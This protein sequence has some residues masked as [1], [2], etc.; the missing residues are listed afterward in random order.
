M[1]ETKTKTRFS[2]KRRNLKSERA[3]KT[4]NSTQKEKLAS[5]NSDAG[6]PTVS[7]IS[8]EEA[9][10][11]DLELFNEYQFSVD[12]LMELAGYSC[13]VAIAKAYPLNTLPKIGGTVLICVGPGNNGGDGL[14][15]ARHLKMF[16]Y[17]P[18]IFYPKRPDKTLYKNLAHQCAA[19]DVPF[20][21]YLP[22]SKLLDE[23]YNF[24][25]DAIFGF[26]FKGDVRPPFADVLKT[27]KEI[28]IPLCS[29]DIPSGWDVEKGNPEGISPEM[30]ISLTAPKK[31]A[32]LFKGKHHYLG[33]RF[34]P[35]DLAKKYELNLPDYPGTECC[36]ELK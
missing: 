33:G 16:G 30:L 13:A 36:M 34:V 10:K 31:C 27:L 17:E 14:V 19:L 24:V 35:P 32:Q 8:Q 4:E 25:V 1:S 23:S 26:S 22:N 29:I 6:I 5:I 2:F 21:S 20:L 12:Q 9:Q 15:A 7:F 18:S 11:I 3:D 28:N